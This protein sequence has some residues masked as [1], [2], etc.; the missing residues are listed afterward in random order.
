MKLTK[1]KASRLKFYFTICLS[2]IK[3][4]LVLSDG[5]MMGYV[6]QELCM[7]MGTP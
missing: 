2:Q 1:S 4:L 6:I 3:L 5:V 7:G